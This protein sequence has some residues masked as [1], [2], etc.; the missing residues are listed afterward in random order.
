MKTTATYSATTDIK[1]N[2]ITVEALERILRTIAGS[3]PISGT[4][5]VSLDVNRVSSYQTSTLT[6]VLL[7]MG[8]GMNTVISLR[9]ESVHIFTE[10]RYS[11]FSKCKQKIG[12]MIFRRSLYS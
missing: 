8:A 1:T 7:P 3:L 5:F 2:I 9:L 6:E 10:N 12:E 11:T 4:S